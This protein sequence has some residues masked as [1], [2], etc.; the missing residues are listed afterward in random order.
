M[1]LAT[2]DLGTNTVRLLVA[3]SP[4]PPAW[5]LVHHEQQVTRLGEGLWPDRVL[6]DAPMTR[7]AAAVAA[8][9][10]RAR[11]LGADVV[12]I[13]ATS[14]VREALNGPAYAARLEAATGVAVEVVSGEDEARLTIRG[15][16]GALGG[17]RGAL[18]GVSGT[19]LVFD[20]GGGSTEYILARGRDVV[21]SVSLHLGVVRLAE[22]FPFPD[23]VEPARY[24]AMEDEVA[25]QL[26]RE[27]PPAI[28]GA[29]ID[30]LVGTAGTVTALAAIDLG[31]TTYD[32]DRVQGHRLDRD[33]VR[34]Q[35]ARLGALTVRQRAAVPCLEPGRADLIVPGIAIVLATMRTLSAPALVVSDAGLRE[36][37]MSE[38]VARLAGEA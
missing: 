11:A 32:G 18:G 38:A 37:M 13:A 6:R 5:R 29:R 15:V 1:R 7:T 24:Q 33:T 19:L 27:L 2:I 8:Y 16:R 21:A 14:A 34:G 4:R 31:L 10:E 22:R 23:P 30:H 9:V 28:T 36:G 25:A 20:I 17:V 12:R 3:E 26:A 35:L